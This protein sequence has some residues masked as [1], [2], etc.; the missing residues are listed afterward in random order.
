V[1][2]CVSRETGSGGLQAERAVCPGAMRR[3]V[4]RDSGTAASG[5][6]LSLPGWLAGL[7]VAGGGC[8]VDGQGSIANGLLL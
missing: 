8:R 5:P 2:S 4:R 7:V 3:G 6:R 1:S